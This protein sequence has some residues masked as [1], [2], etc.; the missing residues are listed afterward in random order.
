MQILG[1]RLLYLFLDQMKSVKNISIFLFCFFGGFSNLSAQ[2]LF[3]GNGFLYDDTRV[4]R[5]DISIEPQYLDSILKPGNE[6]KDIEYPASFKI[7][8]GQDVVRLDSVGFRLRGNTSRYAAKKSFK[9]SFNS[10]VAGQKFDK[11][12]KINLNG[13][14][15]DPSIARSKVCWDLFRL[16][17]VP[18]PRSGHVELYINNEYRGLYINVEHID[19]NFTKI[20][21]G[22]NDGNM[23]KCLW[24][25][26]LGFRGLNPDVYKFESDNRR[27]YELTRN[28]EIDDYTDLAYL[29]AVLNNIDPTEFPQLL[30]PIFDVNTYLKDL[31]VEILTG[32]WDDYSFNQNNYYLYHDE[33]SGRF[34]YIPY[35]L[36]NTFGIDW[37]NI[38][39]AN[40]DIYKWFSQDQPRPLTDKILRNQTYKDRFSFYM[41]RFLDEYFNPAY[42]EPVVSSL[43][44]E[45]APYVTEDMYHTYDYGY[46]YTDFY[47]SF[48]EATGAHVKYGMLPFINQRNISAQQQLV[49]A[50]IAPIISWVRGNHPGYNENFLIS[51]MVEDEETPQTV[52]LY[53]SL[54]GDYT[55]VDMQSSGKDLFLS[56]IPG[57]SQAGILR[58]YI[59][60][61]DNQSQLSREPFSGEYSIQVGFAVAV[62]EYY[63]SST[64]IN[65]YPNPF[66][67]WFEISCTGEFEHIDYQLF[68]MSG[69]KVAGG[70]SYEN[71]IRVYADESNLSGGVYF[72]KLEVT[73]NN[74]RILYHENRKMI[75]V[76]QF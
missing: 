9:I 2:N 54:G 64:L 69:R 3:P 4:N 27:A 65:V 35:D 19:E 6:S 30:E 59:E 70:V 52:K 17:G 45:I 14:H 66:T 41:K 16:A 11:V 48:D 55:P 34:E 75:F 51:A 1:L 49:T 46:S 7:T 60:A 73:G 74:D 32:D 50:N 31:V 29:I 39:W 28:E 22:N 15:N 42:L 47:N 20:R 5:I 53:Y 62:P 63:S 23:Y 37:F 72:L 67:S 13:E 26:N 18:A 44:D 21:Y 68:D 57:I 33:E 36:D 24:P 56:I 71:P 25:A 12:E 38:D 58:Y 61:T 76:K 8:R 43:R 40:R 10:F